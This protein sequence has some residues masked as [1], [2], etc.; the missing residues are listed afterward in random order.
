[1]SAV[2]GCASTLATSQPQE[3]HCVSTEPRSLERMSDKDVIALPKPSL[4]M[5]RQ[6]TRTLTRLYCRSGGHQLRI[7]PDGSV[8]GGRQDND[9]YDI[10]RLKAVSAGVVVVTGENTGRYLAM[11][12]KGSLYGS[13]TLND[14]CY[15]HEKYE[16]N[17][18]N[19]YCSKKY[20]WYVALKRNGKP[21]LGPNTDQGQKAILFLP[22]SADA[23]NDVNDGGVCVCSPPMF[24]GKDPQDQPD[25]EST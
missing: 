8:N 25:K 19:T 11:N 12:T 15:F 14:E 23:S 20:N 5:S 4:D 21:K 2:G 10:L 17:N 3:H 7:L 13:L 9:P 16:E 6:G 22:L 18:Y 24:H 1:M